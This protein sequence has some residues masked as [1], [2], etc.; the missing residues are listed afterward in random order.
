MLQR[1]VQKLCPT[2]ESG[3]LRWSLASS[4]LL[5]L[6]Y[7]PVS[8]GLV[9]WV[10]PVC[11][12]GWVLAK[13]LPGRWPYLKFWAAGALFWLLAVHWIRLPHPL[14]YLAW[15]A[16]SAYLGI[17][18]PLFIALGRVAVHRMRVPLWIAA[19]TV[20]TGLDLV[21]GHLISG[22]LM[23]SLA[24]T[25]VDSLGLIQ[26]A[27]MM[28]EYGVTFLIVLVA[29]C[30][31][32]VCY[33]QGPWFSLA[34]L[35]HFCPAVIALVAAL[36]YG[37][38]KL[39]AYRRITPN[40]PEPLGP[41]IA[42][43]Q[44]NTLADWK[45][46]PEKQSRIM[47]EHVQLSRQ[48]VAD[49]ASQ[50]IDLIIWP[51]TSFRQTLITTADGY[52]PP[53]ERV[54]ESMLTVAQK[55][56]TELVRET[57]TP[58]LVGIDRMHL[59][60][61]ELGE[62]AYSN[63]N[64]SVLVDPQGKIIGTYDKMHRVPFGE[65]I[66]MAE[67]LPWLYELTP[68]TGGIKPGESPTAMQLNGKTYAVN[69]CYESV[70]P[71]LIRQHVLQL[72]DAKTPPDVLVNLT[73]DAW[74]WGS[75]ELDMHLACGIYRAIETRTPLVI[76]ANGGLSAHVDHTGLVLEVSERQRPEALLVDVRLPKH[77]AGYPSL[78]IAWGDWFAGSCLL[79]CMVLAIVSYRDRHCPATS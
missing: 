10:A 45:S 21:R 12:I 32:Q 13:Q 1:A 43:I 58:V 33:H 24:H 74:F 67:W 41:R 47:Q 75:S 49:S 61:D 9:A 17:Y 44:G 20:W 37:N 66:P 59:F 72:T 71:H 36:V 68:L 52:T 26:I 29:S 35:W 77:G 22:F 30:L 70:V 6:A 38:S 34:R 31:A 25:Q 18:L 42:L 46:D 79:C 4:V 62:L 48:A 28:G 73:N 55:D 60:A 78:Y 8:W 5:W 16:L 3:L 23:G 15:V 56:L 63:Y 53:P 40:A 57:G 19:P 51:E 7:P 27:D 11:W 2:L 65:Y 64:S 50:K 69:I 14:N 76:A 54:H 39:D